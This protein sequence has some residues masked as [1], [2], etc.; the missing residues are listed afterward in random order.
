MT[1]NNYKHWFEYWVTTKNLPIFQSP[2]AE[3]YGGSNIEPLASI[4][5]SCFTDAIKNDFKENLSII[6]YGCGAGILSNFISERLDKFTY[7][8]LEPS[9]GWGPQRIETGRKY[10]ND[11][12]VNFGFTEDYKTIIQNNKI[13]AVILISVFTHL[14][15]EDS[16]SILDELKTIFDYN[17][18]ASIVFSCFTSDSPRIGVLENYINSN[19]YSDSFIELK[20]L[21]DYCKN[22]N[23]N[24]TKW[25][26]FVAQSGHTHEIFKITKL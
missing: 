24:L 6:D 12:R 8:G 2:P 3:A 19:Y 4:G 14:H 18:N 5:M 20:E 15:I 21:K 22:N 10:F 11:P 9:T 7:F 13:D 1:N 17:K 23:L 25:M 16:F 26:D